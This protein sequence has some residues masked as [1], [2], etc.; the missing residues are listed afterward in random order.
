MSKDFF[1]FAMEGREGE[2]RRK[3]VHCQIT[4]QLYNP[5]GPAHELD[6]GD[7]EDGADNQGSVAGPA[8][9][10]PPSR[11]AFPREVVEAEGGQT[12]CCDVFGGDCGGD[13]DEAILLSLYCSSSF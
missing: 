13:D 4:A 2:A 1:L 7:G 8:G 3:D 11:I 12:C 10:V 9:D 5:D 6:D